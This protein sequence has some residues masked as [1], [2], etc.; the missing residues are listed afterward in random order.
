MTSIVGFAHHSKVG[1]LLDQRLQATAHEFVI[2][3]EE[4]AGFSHRVSGVL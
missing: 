2:V 1:L 4:D 3:G